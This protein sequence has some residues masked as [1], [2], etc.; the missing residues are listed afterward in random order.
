MLGFKFCLYYQLS[1]GFITTALPNSHNSNEPNGLIRPITTTRE[2]ASCPIP[3]M[4]LER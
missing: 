2:E 3:S 1:G 4:L